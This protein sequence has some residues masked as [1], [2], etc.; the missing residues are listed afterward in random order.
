MKATLQKCLLGVGGPTTGYVISISHAEDWLRIFSLLI[1]I[2]VGC[3]S[4]VSI[5]L[6]IHRKWTQ[7]NQPIHRKRRVHYVDDDE[8][9]TTI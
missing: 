7:K 5:G 4:A 1:G 2:F 9:T 8:P 6:S 3:L